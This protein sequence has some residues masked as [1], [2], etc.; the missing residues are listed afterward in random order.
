[1]EF[2]WS[3]WH[4]SR[5]VNSLGQ[6]LLFSSPLPFFFSV[7][8]QTTLPI[9]APVLLLEENFLIPSPPSPPPPP[10]LLPCPLKKL[11]LN[12]M[13]RATELSLTWFLSGRFSPLS[14]PRII[15]CFFVSVIQ[16]LTFFPFFARRL[17]ISNLTNRAIDRS[18]EAQR[19][20]FSFIQRWIV[21]ELTTTRYYR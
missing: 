8:C 12:S 4:F 6:R 21:T 19:H 1:M 3:S 10:P 7:T 15:Q 18:L 9:A 2:P 20:D 14:R 5:S 13:R 16:I 11:M 17:W